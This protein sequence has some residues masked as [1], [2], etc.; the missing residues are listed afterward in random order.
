MNLR[1]LSLL[2]TLSAFGLSLGGCSFFDRGEDRDQ[3]SGLTNEEQFEIEED[4]VLHV[5]VDLMR[6]RNK[7]LKQI[8]I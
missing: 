4:P 8:A 3:F 7:P 1:T 6:L 5:W 2:F